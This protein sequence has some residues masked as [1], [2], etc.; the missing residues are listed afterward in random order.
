MQA[1][2][3]HHD[4]YFGTINNLKNEA[5]EELDPTFDFNDAPVAVAD[6]HA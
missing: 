1:R 2:F 6:P 4:T 3:L 5:L